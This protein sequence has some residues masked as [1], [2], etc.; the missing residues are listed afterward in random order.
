DPR[1][2]SDLHKWRHAA[3]L[4]PHMERWR[5]RAQLDHGPYKRGQG[6]CKGQG[7]EIWSPSGGCSAQRQKA[8]QRLA[9]GETQADVARS[10]KVSQATISRLGPIPFG[11][12][13]A[14]VEAGLA[15]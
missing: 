7:R 15:G 9:D 11:V 14:Q 1:E 13:P 5:V 10:Y 3:G 6:R 4:S 12:A 2:R 8:I